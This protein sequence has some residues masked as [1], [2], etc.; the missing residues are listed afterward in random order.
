MGATR[1][2]QGRH[3]QAGGSGRRAGGIKTW[4]YGSGGRR[5][6]EDPDSRAAG[7]CWV[8]YRTE[9]RGFMYVWTCV[10]WK[11]MSVKQSRRGPYIS[12]VRCVTRCLYNGNSRYFCMHLFCLIFAQRYTRVYIFTSRNFEVKVTQLAW[13]KKTRV[14]RQGEKPQEKAASLRFVHWNFHI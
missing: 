6:R 1:Y 12:T 7:K 9:I 2:P 11:F 4:L 10:P 5:L 14:C 13:E 3:E 8:K